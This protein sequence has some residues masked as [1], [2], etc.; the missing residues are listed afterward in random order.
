MPARPPSRGERLINIA[1]LVLSLVMAM[2][3]IT[4]AVLALFPAEN[5][6]PHLLA[7][8]LPGYVWRTLVLMAGVGA[9]S[10]II[11]TSTA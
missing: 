9:L 4:V 10:F 3:V 8:V 6:W 1:I 2:P 5:I 11:G 7:T